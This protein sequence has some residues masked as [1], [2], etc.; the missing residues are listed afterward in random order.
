MQPPS[1]LLLPCSHSVALNHPEVYKKMWVS[2]ETWILPQLL[3]SSF[4][5]SRFRSLPSPDTP[6]PYTLWLPC[7]LC[8]TLFPSLP[9]FYSF[10]PLSLSPVLSSQNSQQWWC[11]FSISWE[12]LTLC[13]FPFLIYLSIPSFFFF[14]FMERRLISSIQGVKY[15]SLF[16]AWSLI[17]WCSSYCRLLPFNVCITVLCQCFWINIFCLTSRKSL[18]LK[19]VQTYPFVCQLNNVP[20]KRIWLNFRRHNKHRGGKKAACCR[21]AVFVPQV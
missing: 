20:I 9:L 14:V 5:S 21:D 19:K 1:R 10:A 2:W 13:Q 7:L 15:P 6:S 17:V 18:R 12:I 11:R 4:F 3:R 16:A 8:H